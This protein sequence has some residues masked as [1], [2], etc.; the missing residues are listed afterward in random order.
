MNEVKNLHAEFLD[1]GAPRPPFFIGWDSL[2]DKYFVDLPGGYTDN[3]F[4]EFNKGQ[5]YVRQ[6]CDT[7]DA[8]AWSHNMLIGD[9]LEATRKAILRDVFGRKKRSKL[10]TI[11]TLIEL[12]NIYLS[13]FLPFDAIWKRVIS[14]RADI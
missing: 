1:H 13:Y 7:P 11:V 12:K 9:S 14:E 8:E 5:V 3:F 6:L 10:V 4:F 2:L